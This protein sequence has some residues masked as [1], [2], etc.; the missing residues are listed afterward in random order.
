MALRIQY[1][2]TAKKLSVCLFDLFLARHRKRE[3][4]EATTTVARTADDSL[5][6][7]HVVALVYVYRRYISSLATN[8]SIQQDSSVSSFHILIH[9]TVSVKCTPK[10]RN[11]ALLLR[12]V[13]RRVSNKFDKINKGQEA[14]W[15]HRR[16]A[17]PPWKR[18]LDERRKH[19]P[20]PHP[21]T[22]SFKSSTT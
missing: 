3:R 21:R 11:A 8:V 10:N 2:H 18:P 6:S 19:S 7:E 4:S 20:S 14:K 22:A 5:N 15:I 17:D 13:T 12:R 9:P 1:N 16:T